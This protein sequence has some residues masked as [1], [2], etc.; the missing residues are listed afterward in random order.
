[1]IHP[2]HNGTSH[3]HGGGAGEDG[4]RDARVEEP[5]A[6]EAC[7]G[8]LVAGAAAGD[9]CYFLFVVLVLGG[10]AVEDFVGRVEG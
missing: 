2:P 3:L 9:E 8:G 5:G 6:D 10:A 7:E 4:T 1:M